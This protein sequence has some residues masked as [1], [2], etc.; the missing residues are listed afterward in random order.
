MSHPFDLANDRAFRTWRDRRLAAYPAAAERLRVEV[1]SLGSPSRAELAAIGERLSRYNA[2]WVC[3]APSEV[4]PQAVVAFGQALGLRRTDANL[5][6]DA[7]A[8]SAI[9]P[10][11]AADQGEYVPY[12]DKPLNWHTDGYYNAPGAQVRAWTL[13][14][15]HQAAEGGE[16]AF[17]DHEVLYAL[18]REESAQHV[19]ALSHPQAL[20]IPAN[21]VEG[22]EL[23]ARSVGPVFSVR[24]GSLHLRYSARGRNVE[25]RDDPATLAARD[26]M[27]RLLSQSP[28]YTFDLK[29]GPG[30][31]LVSHNVPH[32]RS[33]FAPSCEGQPERLLY[34]VR[35][36]ERVAIRS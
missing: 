14:C 6:A 4:T 2:A 17:M 35:Y 7:R 11:S 26:A 34:R 13:F 12:T 22:R 10:S 29:L 19:R 18:L 36:L 25:W 15:R 9:T 27:L 23:R 21:V 33:G 3:G 16:N 8:V 32:R 24:E 5:F 31:G 20:S 1:R 28:S 30:E